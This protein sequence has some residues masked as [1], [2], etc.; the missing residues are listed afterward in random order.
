MIQADLSSPSL[1]DRLAVAVVMRREPVTGA[2]SR[3]QS[4]R[5]LL[6][7]V[8]SGERLEQLAPPARPGPLPLEAFAGAAGDAGASHWL[9]PGL[10]VE[11]HRD[12]VEGYRLNLES[13]RPC[14]WVMWRPD[15]ARLPDGDA[16]PLPLIV[17]LSY[18]DAGR[19][20]DAQEQV[21]QVPAPAEVV[22]WLARF[23]EAHHRPEPRRRQRPASFQPLAD[24][25]GNPASISTG[26][27]RGRGGQGHDG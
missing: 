23:V 3:W 1:S 12:D 21:E 6:A 25:F 22:A 13:P 5:W 14:F 18:Q 26:A 15:E 19:W 20:L 24:R 16:A 27:R 11:L 17:T 8:L 10:E 9:Y 2:M 7:D 4:E